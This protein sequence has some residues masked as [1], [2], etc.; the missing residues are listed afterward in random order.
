M[1]KLDVLAIALEK[2]SRT[3][4]QGKLRN[5]WRRLAWFRSKL[6]LGADGNMKCVGLWW[7]DQELAFPESPAL[8]DQDGLILSRGELSAIVKAAASFLLQQGIG[9]SD[10]LA[11][12]MEPGLGLVSSLLAGMAVAAIAPLSPTATYHIFYSDLQRLGATRLLVD[13]HPPGAL[14]EAA[15]ALGVPLVPLN[16][17]GMSPVVGELSFLPDPVD[18]ALLLQTSGTTSRPKVV[19]LSHANLL[20]SAQA[21]ADVLGLGSGRPQP[22]GDAAVPH[23]RHRGVINT[24][25]VRTRFTPEQSFRELL[26]QVKASSLSAYDNQELPFEQMLEALNLPRDTS[27]NPLVQVMLQ[28]IELPEAPLINLQGLAVE[29]LEARNGASRFDLEFFLRRS[30]DGLKG[31]IAYATELSSSDRIG[32]LCS[33]LL[34]LLS[35]AVQH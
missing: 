8:F 19:P 33:H 9:H 35:S 24:L 4:E 26:L 13:D 27:R 25:P 20:A 18:L 5:G 11:I 22:G 12:L 29:S 15:S 14:L 2:C 28:L 6:P 21:V 7:L 30:A 1:A 3:T 10:R 32:R 31:E 16:P 34:T 23:P 17:L